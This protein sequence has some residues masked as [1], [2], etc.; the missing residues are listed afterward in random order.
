MSLRGLLVAVALGFGGLASGGTPNRLPEQPALA[1]I[2][3]V[4]SRLMKAR[5]IFVSPACG[6]AIAPWAYRGS[7]GNRTMLRAYARTGQDQA[8][9][10]DFVAAL[11]QASG[12]DSTYKFRGVSKP[13]NQTHQVP[14]FTVTWEGGDVETYALLSFEA[15]C[16]VLFE[17]D[18]PLGAEWLEGRADTLFALIR[19]ALPGD[20]LVQ[21]MN[22]PAATE[23]RLEESTHIPNR[24]LVDRLPEVI[25]KLAPGYPEDARRAGIDGTVFVQ[26]LVGTDGTV[27]DAFSLGGSK[28][29]RILEGSA[30]DAVW[31][32]K[33]SPAADRDGTPIAVWVA[34]PVRFTLH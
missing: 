1:R 14:L 17:A 8:W 32:W 31:H 15:R 13:C 7:R 22:I 9:N 11:L 27:Q 25:E 33:F 12:W 21:D 26:A 19:R 20:S 2:E 18:R 24:A 5:R 29:L 10:A 28:K 34:V 23:A 6:S 30:V 16:A 4:R 3:Q